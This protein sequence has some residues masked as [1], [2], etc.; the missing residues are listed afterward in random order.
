MAAPDNAF[1][2]G[3]VY[4]KVVSGDTNIHK[5]SDA[6]D[7]APVLD[8][9]TA[10]SFPDGYSSIG[11]ICVDS[12]RNLVATLGLD[13]SSN[14]VVQVGH[15]GSEAV[16]LNTYDAGHYGSD[17]QNQSQEGRRIIFDPVTGD[18]LVSL[19]NDTNW[20]IRRLTFDPSALTLTTDALAYSHAWPD[21]GPYPPL[22][23]SSTIR[24]FS[25]TGLYFSTNLG[26]SGSGVYEVLTPTTERHL[27]GLTAPSLSMR[28]VATSDGWFWVKVWYLGHG[29]QSR[30]IKYQWASG[31][32]NI[33]SSQVII[34]GLPYDAI[35]TTAPLI[36]SPDE[37]YFAWATMEDSTSGAGAVR[38]IDR[39]G[40]TILTFPDAP[41]ASFP[42]LPI[43]AWSGPLGVGPC[44]PP[45]NTAAPSITETSPQIREVTLHGHDGTWD[46]GINGP[47]TYHYQWQR[48]AT[49]PPDVHGYV[50]ADI[51]GETGV[52]YT[53]ACADSNQYLRLRVTATNDCGASGSAVT[54]V[55]QVESNPPQTGAVI[56]TPDTGITCGTNIHIDASGFTPSD[57]TYSYQWQRKTDT[58][59]NFVTTSVWDN[60]GSSSA[61][62]KTSSADIGHALRCVVTAS[63][64]D[65]SAYLVS[66]ESHSVSGG[67]PININ[68]PTITPDTGLHVQDPHDT[69]PELR[70]DP[71]TWDTCNIPKPGTPAIT[72]T[73]EWY[74]YKPDGSDERLETHVTGHDDELFVKDAEYGRKFRVKVTAHAGSSAFAYSDFT[75]NVGAHAPTLKKTHPT[76]DGSSFTE[77]DHDPTKRLKVN[78]GNLAAVTA[79]FD[80]GGDKTMYLEFQFV[81]CDAKGKRLGVA[82]NWSRNMFYQL[83]CADIGKRFQGYV[84]ATNSVGSTVV[85]CQQFLTFALGK[86]NVTAMSALFPVLWATPVSYVAH[87]HVP[88]IGQNPKIVTTDDVQNI[89]VPDGASGTYILKVLD[90]APENTTGP[91]KVGA[92]AASLQKTLRALGGI[93]P[94]GVTVTGTGASD[95]P[96]VV[97]FV[98]PLALI[99]VSAI[100]V[101]NSG[102]NYGATPTVTP[103]SVTRS[104]H[105]QPG[106]WAD[107]PTDT[108]ADYGSTLTLTSPGLWEGSCSSAYTFT[109]QWYYDPAT[110][111]PGATGTSYVTSSADLY[112]DSAGKL[113][114]QKIYCLVTGGNLPQLANST[115]KSNAVTI[116]PIPI[117]DS[118]AAIVGT[119]QDAKSICGHGPYASLSVNPGSVSGNLPPGG[120]LGYDYKWYVSNNA[121]PDENE[122]KAAGALSTDS[123]FVLDYQT[124]G[125]WAKCYYTVKSLN[126]DGSVDSTYGPIVLVSSGIVIA[127]PPT[128]CVAPTLDAIEFEAG[129]TISCF[130]GSWAGTS[131]PPPTYQ[132]QTSTDGGATW[133]DITDATTSTYIP[134]AGDI[135]NLIR[136]QVCE[137]NT[138]LTGGGV[139]CAY[140]D[141][142]APIS[143]FVP[144]DSSPNR[145]KWL[146]LFTAGNDGRLLA[147]VKDATQKDVNMIYNG[148]DVATVTLSQFTDE[149]Q[150]LVTS[151]ETEGMPGCQV[152]SLDTVSGEMVLRFY[153]VLSGMQED[154]DGQKMTATLKATF[155]C[156]ACILQHRYTIDPAAWNDDFANVIT[157]LIEQQNVRPHGG[158]TGI[159]WPGLGTVGVSADCKFNRQDV[160]SAIHSLDGEFDLKW[161]YVGGTTPGAVGP[162]PEIV[163][164]EV[165][166]SNS[167]GVDRTEVRFQVS[168]ASFQNILHL[169]RTTTAPINGATVHGA[170]GVF[171]AQFDTASGD[172][173]GIYEVDM[174]APTDLT[175]VPTLTNL[176]DN[177]LTRHGDSD[178]AAPL[179]TITID[180]A[181][182]PGNVPQPFVDFNVAD[183]VYLDCALGT[184]NM[185]LAVRINSFSVALDADEKQTYSLTFEASA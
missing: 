85:E 27:F 157:N 156:P 116:L 12:T 180:P 178:V 87:S 17:M 55:I 110:P 33:E 56:L 16:V 73:T 167:L 54:S 5:T 90:Y 34:V 22:E 112:I 82:G 75:G 74:S 58:T 92:S 125:L 35:E 185:S 141:A 147:W 94:S 39:T 65:G 32:G 173:Y 15:V 70:S 105:I 4:Q 98:G 136:C 91:I 10:L 67:P 29:I 50:W 1:N 107:P 26:D 44:D 81:R 164:L 108:Q 23:I 142:T 9:G 97:T 78:G 48:S 122:A 71:G 13:G 155:S 171:G 109:Y 170:N 144:I 80:N 88:I 36:M 137:D 150:K 68:K 181:A 76:L 95:N 127:Q 24:S 153:G 139:A 130:P 115:A 96:Y 149:A 166:P 162:F 53:T 158:E 151:L 84:R 119:L 38:I 101:D 123:T 62:Y 21:A 134:I 175:H 66:H 121:T 113:A 126:P 104:P 169:Q 60:V 172:L 111:I 145:L 69:T 183:T 79:L 40:A 135:G 120:S 128:N 159:R 131:L 99:H 46:T 148:I 52:D 41:D 138:F 163:D 86:K 45:V 43:F 51:S 132:W 6:L 19:I 100:T 146:Y 20:E 129:A 140:T 83:A 3:F 18:L 8:A 7:T 2:K 72:Y 49:A 102:M 133:N 11:D 14:P 28:F 31:M 182:T 160:W 177:Y 168:P 124:Y 161:T 103:T 106:V 118:G 89:V 30:W 184:V 174:S 25:P 37:Q 42:L 93:A 61:D 165:L 47:F 64:C 57:V 176:A 117:S 179:K 59:V 63:N 114:G 152:W 77:A 154:I 143:A